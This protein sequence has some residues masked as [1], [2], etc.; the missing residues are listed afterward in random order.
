VTDK[1]LKDSK[2]KK[3]NQS[4]LSSKTFDRPTLRFVNNIT[5]S[6]LLSLSF[7]IIYTRHL[8]QS[9]SIAVYNACTVSREGP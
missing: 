5:G 9:L 4:F 3:G 8:Y 6:H 1:A 2:K 7:G